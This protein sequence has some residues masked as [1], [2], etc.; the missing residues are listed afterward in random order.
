VASNARGIISAPRGARL[1]SAASISSGIWFRA[2]KTVRHLSR[3]V[4]ALLYH[5]I[6]AG[7]PALDIGATTLDA[8]ARGVRL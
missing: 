3:L 1:S 4:R 5:I 6:K 7:I 2:S 8:R